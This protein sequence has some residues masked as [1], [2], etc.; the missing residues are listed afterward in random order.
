MIYLYDPINNYKTPTNYKLLEDLTGKLQCNLCSYKTKRR[1]IKSLNAYLID[2]SFTKEELYKLMCKEV[3]SD[4]IWKPLNINDKYLISNYGRVK[5]LYMNGKSK[6]ITPFLKQ[7]KWMIIKIN[8]DGK[9]RQQ[10][11]HVLVAR[12]FLEVEP[13][14]VIYHKDGNKFKNHADNLGFITREDIG[15]KFGGNAKAVPVLKLDADTGEVLDSYENIREAGRENYLCHEAIRQCVKGINKTSGG[16]KW[17][18]D[19]EFMKG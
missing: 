1:K 2:D 15:H 10:V 5:R 17:V 8:V 4:E 19:K 14:K 18:I 3:I 16:F 6:L 13:G 11:L 9:C 12:N 7:N